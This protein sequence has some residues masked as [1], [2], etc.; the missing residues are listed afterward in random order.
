MGLLSSGR[1]P[2]RDSV[3]TTLR[4]RLDA[5]HQRQIRRR[6]LIAQHVTTTPN[7]SDQVVSAVMRQLFT[8]L[9]DEDIDDFDL[10]LVHAAIQV[11]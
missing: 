6:I 8:K 7:R 4:D 11:V 2:C 3:P 9:A 10:R 5:V 1:Y